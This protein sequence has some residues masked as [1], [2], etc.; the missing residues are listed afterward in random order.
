MERRGQQRGG[1]GQ[2]GVPRALHVAALS[3][4]NGNHARFREQSRTICTVIS[5]DG[6]GRFFRVRV[7]EVKATEVS[8]RTKSVG[9]QPIPGFD[10]VRHL[11]E[12]RSGLIVG[13][14]LFWSRGGGRAHNTLE[15]KNISN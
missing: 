1:M 15:R 7:L 10:A 4:V 11:P 9:I 6:I 2:Q 14:G 3:K 13:C 8:F 12:T 5:V